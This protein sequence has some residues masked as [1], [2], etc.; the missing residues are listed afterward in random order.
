[1][2]ETSINIIIDAINRT[3]KTFKDTVSSFDTLSNSVAL[4]AGKFLVIKNAAEQFFNLVV[5]VAQPA[6]DAVEEFNLSIAKMTALII[7]LQDTTGNDDIASQYQ[8]ANNY[9]KELV[10]TL[11]KLSAE[12]LATGKETRLIAEE[13]LKQGI[14]IKNTVKEYEALKNITNAVATIAAGSLNREL[15]VREEI[16]SLVSGTLRPGSE[17]ARLINTQTGDLKGQLEIWKSTGSVIENLGKQTAGFGSISKDIQGTWAVIGT[18]LETIQKRILREGFKST[19]EAINSTLTDI[20]KLL[21]DQSELISN[22]LN[23]ALVSTRGIIE[24]IFIILETSLK[25]ILT[26]IKPLLPLVNLIAEGIGVTAS[27]L[28]AVLQLFKDI[29]V[30]LNGIVNLITLTGIGIKQLTS[31]DLKG[32]TNTQ[33]ILEAQKDLIEKDFNKALNDF[34]K[35]LTKTANKFFNIT[36]EPE[37]ETKTP[38]AKKP[39]EETEVRTLRIDVKTSKAQQ[40][41][42][43]KLKLDEELFKIQEKNLELSFQKQEI[44]EKE[45]NKKKRDLSFERLQTTIES[46]ELSKNVLKNDLDEKLKVLQ[47][48]KDK[49]KETADYKKQVAAIDAQISAQRANIVKTNIQAEIDILKKAADIDKERIQASQKSF[50]EQL[51]R[52]REINEILLQNSKITPLEA[53]QQE[54][55]IERQIIEFKIESLKKTKD[56][57]VSEK[58]RIK[59]DGELLQLQNSLSDSEKE[60]L[61]LQQAKQQTL[62]LEKDRVIALTE[63]KLKLAELKNDYDE[64]LNLKQELSKLRFERAVLDTGITPDFEKVLADTAAFQQKQFEQLKT[65]FGA[66]TAGFD[67]IVAKFKDTSSQMLDIGRNLAQGLQQTF[68][69]TFFNVITGRFDSIRSALSSLV[70]LIARELSRV[71]SQQLVSQIT[72]GL[73]SLFGGIFHDGGIVLDT[74]VSRLKRFHNG[75]LNN[76]ERMIVAQTGEGIVSRNGMAS[77]F[78]ALNKGN[79]NN[80]NQGQ[81]IDTNALVNGI[82]AAIQKQPITIVNNLALKKGIEDYLD[83]PSGRKK[84]NSFQ[85]DIQ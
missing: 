79:L 61:Q 31:F 15:Q 20:N 41:I 64:V 44:T 24:S 25:P 21:D 42:Q 26:I 10:L 17:L 11:E 14:I 74:P 78:N 49:L 51:K 7:G 8:S 18:T 53:K 36:T 63:E 65:P 71:A 30:V 2:A 75:G 56:I 59:I 6:Y 3:E 13:L 69:D 54:I 48:E 84:I 80:A 46:L 66:L 38:T 33:K 39:I 47:T 70:D 55:D 43:A 45:F 1:M 73:T 22:S 60:L 68:E 76:D 50:E 72:P 35:N 58:E 77:L 34:D 4:A 5:G 23:K 82:A 81:S 85:N 16:R 62:Q 27:I 40:Q 29:A 28:P 52:Q 32:F 19:Y 37:T 83:S 9:A 57:T 12:T 67:E